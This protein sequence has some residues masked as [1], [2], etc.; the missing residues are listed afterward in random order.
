MTYDSV[1]SGAGKSRIQGIG[2]PV[3]YAGSDSVLSPSAYE[4]FPDLQMFP[5]MAG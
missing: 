5:T 2:G 4:E 1:G 3:E